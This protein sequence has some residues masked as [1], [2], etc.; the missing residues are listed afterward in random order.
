MHAAHEAEG[1][2]GRVERRPVRTPRSLERHG[3]G[4]AARQQERLRGAS[5]TRQPGHAST[6]TAKSEARSS[7][8]ASR[9]C[10][11]GCCLAGGRRPGARRAAASARQLLAHN[12]ELH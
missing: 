9:L 6:R 4:G 12:C 7:I 5:A 8:E 3:A 2:R 10:R 11:A 1:V